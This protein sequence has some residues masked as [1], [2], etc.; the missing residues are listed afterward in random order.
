M[1]SSL[2]FVLWRCGLIGLLSFGIAQL[3]GWQPAPLF[4]AVLVGIAA[5]SIVTLFGLMR[6]SGERS[7]IH[8]IL[9]KLRKR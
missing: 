6:A 8:G 3:Y 2:F 1:R 9:E 4:I 5:D 7:I